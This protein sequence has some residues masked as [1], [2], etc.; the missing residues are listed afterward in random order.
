MAAAGQIWVEGQCDN[1]DKRMRFP[2]VP[3]FI[4]PKKWDTVQDII[5]STSKICFVP[6]FWL[7]CILVI[8]VL[9]EGDVFINPATLKHAGSLSQFS[10]YN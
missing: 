5:P 3:F 8:L 9:I 7:K 4:S 6:F 2:E 1:K 10:N